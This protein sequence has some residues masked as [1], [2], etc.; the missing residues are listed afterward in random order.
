MRADGPPLPA[1]RIECRQ[2]ADELAVDVWLP[3]EALPARGVACAVGLSAVIESTDG[4]LSNWAL[5]HP[6]PV[7]DF[8]DRAGWVA[9]L[10]ASGILE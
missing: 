2:T 5:H 9:R 3:I 6:K 7:P 10:S 1:P 4:H 8:H